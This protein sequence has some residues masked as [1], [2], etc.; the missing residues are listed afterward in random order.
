MTSEIAIRREERQ[1][2]VN[3]PKPSLN[4]A[5]QCSKKPAFAVHSRLCLAH[6]GHSTCL[7]FILVSFPRTG[8]LGTFHLV[9]HISDLLCFR[10]KH[11]DEFIT[12]AIRLHL[13]VLFTQFMHV[14]HLVTFGCPVN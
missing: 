1:I 14:R 13:V 4:G 8:S 5:E 3:L 10:K 2:K 6:S 12:L 7:R 9:D 11:Q